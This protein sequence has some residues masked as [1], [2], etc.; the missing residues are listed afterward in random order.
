MQTT[1]SAREEGGNPKFH[2]RPKLHRDLDVTYLPAS[3][4]HLIHEAAAHT[5]AQRDHH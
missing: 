2:I 3:L 1:L 4:V 5:R